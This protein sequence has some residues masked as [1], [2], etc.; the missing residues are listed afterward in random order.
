MLGHAPLA[1]QPLGAS[2]ASPAG[3]N[4]NALPAT[5]EVFY[6]VADSLTPNPAP[7]SAPFYGVVDV[8]VDTPNEATSS[9]FYDEAFPSVFPDIVTGVPAQ[10]PATTPAPSLSNTT[11]VPAQLPALTPAPTSSVTVGAPAQPTDLLGSGV[12]TSTF[13]HTMFSRPAGSW[14]TPISHAT[15]LK[16]GSWSTPL[17]HEVKFIPLLNPT[18][19]VLDQWLL[20]EPT[21]SGPLFDH[22]AD[23]IP[24]K[25]TGPTFDHMAITAGPGTGAI[26][27]HEAGQ[28]VIPLTSS[29]PLFD[30][31]AEEAPPLIIPLDP[32][33]VAPPE[34]K[35]PNQLAVP[36]CVGTGSGLSPGTCGREIGVGETVV[37]ST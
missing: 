12:G 20:A 24:G 23:G 18:G 14:A 13:P 32:N 8:L 26:F 31:D 10:Q 15:T 11:G 29:G 35:I 9:V 37:R 1:S 2:P 7:T 30:H 33:A 16:T 27:D 34:L 4:P 17:S 22:D 21:P 5:S 3:T 6:G 25:S 19:P 28:A 36:G